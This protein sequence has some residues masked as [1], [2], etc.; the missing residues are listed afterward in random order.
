M[1]Q[2]LSE[3]E[4]ATPNPRRLYFHGGRVDEI[5]AT[6]V[7]EVTEGLLTTEF[8]Y[9]HYDA[10]GHCSLLTDETGAIRERVEYDAFGQAYFYDPSGGPATVVSPFGNRFLFTGREQLGPYGLPSVYDFRHRLYSPEFGRFLQPDPM[11]FKG[12]RTSS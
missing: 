10:R 11:G 7:Y 4:G 1:A 12:N 2:S 5:V 9:H 6:R 8:A 3:L